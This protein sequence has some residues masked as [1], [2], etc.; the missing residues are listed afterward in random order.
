M[1]CTAACGSFSGSSDC[2]RHLVECRPHVRRQAEVGRVRRRVQAALRIE[3]G[4]EAEHVGPLVDAHGA[5][6]IALHGRDVERVQPEGAQW[7]CEQRSVAFRPAGQPHAAARSS[8]D[9]PGLTE[10]DDGHERLRRC[11]PGAG[12]I[13]VVSRSA[14][15]MWRRL[16]TG[17][18]AQDDAVG[19]LE[20]ADVTDRRAA[21]IRVGRRVP[22]VREPIEHQLFQVVLGAQQSRLNCEGKA[23]R[24]DECQRPGLAPT[25]LRRGRP[26][27]VKPQCANADEEAGRARI[28]GAGC[29]QAHAKVGVVERH[30]LAGP[31]VVPAPA[32]RP[33]QRR[34]RDAIER[35][36]ALRQQQ[37]EEQHGQPHQDRKQA[38]GEMPALDELEHQGTGKADRAQVG[39]PLEVA[40]GKLPAQPE[41]ARAL[42]RQRHARRGRHEIGMPAP[43]QQAGGEQEWRWLD[44]QTSG[45]A[46]NEAPTSRGST[47]CITTPSS[48]TLARAS[49]TSTSWRTP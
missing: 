44:H 37:G 49:M 12:R 28:G 3:Q 40:P 13:D 5:Q 30:G 46:R 17:I 27:R 14:Q 35:A 22:A 6:S 34:Q 9:L 24:G 1:A 2:L 18:H 19:G 32:Q 7:Q 15:R 10:R 43:E 41:Q 47:A 38:V 33:E 29:E 8:R 16:T 26:E 48:D 36:V 31:A 21:P 20:L 39:D 45:S 23:G 42:E 25:A 11:I 4:F